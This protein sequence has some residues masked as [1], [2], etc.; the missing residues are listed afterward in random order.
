MNSYYETE[1]EISAALTGDASALWVGMCRQ[2]RDDVIRSV[3]S[4]ESTLD[5]ACDT[6]ATWAR[7]ILDGANE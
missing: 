6:V 1:N 2:D 4:G 7:E 3:R 5:Q